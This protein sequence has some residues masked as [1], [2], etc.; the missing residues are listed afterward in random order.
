MKDKNFKNLHILIAEDDVDDADIITLSFEKCEAFDRVNLV[1][2]GEQLIAFLGDN[3][4]ALPDIILTDL[5]MPKKDGYEAMLDIANDPDFKRIPVFVYSSTINPA[6]ALKCK[7]LGAKDFLI[8]PFR[9]VDFDVIPHQ[10][11]QFMKGELN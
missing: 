9:L 8:K 1:K 3:R 10:I 7:N 5:N 2:N 4:K 6:Y 11:I